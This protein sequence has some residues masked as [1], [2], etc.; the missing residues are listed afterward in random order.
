[1][2]VAMAAAAAVVAA[3]ARTVVL[4]A[5]PIIQRYADVQSDAIM[6]P[7]AAKVTAAV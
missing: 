3:V 4:S 7:P 5:P 1:M 2:A 6:V